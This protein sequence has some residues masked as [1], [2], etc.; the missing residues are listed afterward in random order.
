ME[1]T[2]D[3]IKSFFTGISYVVT[4][5][6]G[7]IGTYYTLK[8]KTQKDMAKAEKQHEEM[9]TTCK[10]HTKMVEAVALIPHVSDD[11]REVKIQLAKIET[12][13][14][15]FI[16]KVQDALMQHSGEIGNIKGKIGG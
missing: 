10:D 13:L 4:A 8:A 1:L 3:M 11:T 2:T 14:D 12:K 5:V 16:D 9:C 6:G 7:A 15:R